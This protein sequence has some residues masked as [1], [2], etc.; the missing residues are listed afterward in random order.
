MNTLYSLF[1][2]VE[3]GL[4]KVTT[5]ASTIE[6]A[7]NLTLGV[8]GSIAVLIITIAGVQYVISQGDPQQTAKAKNTI[9]YAFVGLII[10]AMAFALTRFVINGIG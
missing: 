5:D 9:I 3:T 8:A 4:P 10:V 1:A 7:F 2:Q 6:T